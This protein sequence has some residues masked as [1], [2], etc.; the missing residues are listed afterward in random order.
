[1]GGPCAPSITKGSGRVT[2]PWNN[3]GC[4]QSRWSRVTFAVRGPH[5]TLRNPGG[6][7]GSVGTGN[8]FR[9]GG[10]RPLSHWVG[11]AHRQSPKEV[12]EL[13]R[14]GITL[15]VTKADGLALRLRCG[16]RTLRFA[17]QAGPGVPW[18]Q[19]I[20]F[21][22]AAKGRCPVG[23]AARTVNYR[24]KRMGYSAVKWRWL[25]PK[26]MASRYVCGA[27]AAPYASQPKRDREFRR[28]RESFSPWR[29]KAGVP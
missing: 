13:R 6:T 9:Y 12:D 5:P 17:T 22:M 4:D 14:L 27:G 15:A 11:R 2:A 1:M 24:R 3:V 7:G 23:C 8:R 18:G 25:W 28:D 10:K 29:Q 16:G 26:P 21:A 20:V 19:G